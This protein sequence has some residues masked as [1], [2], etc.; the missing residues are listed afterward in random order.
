M[1][2]L[3]YYFYDEQTGKIIIMKDKDYPDYIDE[4]NKIYEGSLRRLHSTFMAHNI[5]VYMHMH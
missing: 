2:I 1:P 3:L 4:I 5:V